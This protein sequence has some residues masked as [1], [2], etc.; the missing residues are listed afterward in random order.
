[1]HEAFSAQ[2]FGTSGVWDGKVGTGRDSTAFRQAPGTGDSSAW[3]RAW[4][5]C[6]V[7]GQFWQLKGEI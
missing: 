1:M 4:R 2:G 7:I 5:P 3:Q 6:R